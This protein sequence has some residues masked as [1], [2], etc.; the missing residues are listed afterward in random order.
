M[1]ANPEWDAFKGGHINAI[2]QRLTPGHWLEIQ[3]IHRE[4]RI[5]IGSRLP[6][7]ALGD[8]IAWDIA[9]VMRPED[10]RVQDHVIPTPKFDRLK[11]CLQNSPE[12]VA[13]LRGQV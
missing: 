1:S 11:A 2:A 3:H 7:G 8:L 6:V 12:I 13:R 9:A 5:L 10:T 4:G